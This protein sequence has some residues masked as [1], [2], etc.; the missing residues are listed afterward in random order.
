MLVMIRFNRSWKHRIR[1]LAIVKENVNLMN[2]SIS[3]NEFLSFYTDLDLL[4]FFW[5]YY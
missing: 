2:K 5:W 4:L 3:K 1:N